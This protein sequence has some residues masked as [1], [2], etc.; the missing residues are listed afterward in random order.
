MIIN[1]SKAIIFLSVILIWSATVAQDESDEPRVYDYAEDN[2]QCLKCHGHKTYHYYNENLEKDHKDRMNPYFI[3]DSVEFYESNHWN[4]SC[5]D[6]HSYDYNDFPH[7]GEL[8]MEEKLNCLDCHEGDDTYADYNFE[9]IDDEFQKSV[10]STL[11]SEEFTCWM[12]HNPHSYKINA[13]TNDQILETIQY[14]NAICLSCHADID[15]YQLMSELANPNLIDKHEWLPNQ[16]LHFLNVRCIECHAEI[17]EDMMIAHNVQPKEKA[18]KLCV[19]CHSSNSLLLASLY[20]FQ[21]IERRNKLGFVNAA[22]LNNSYIIGANRN[23]YLNVISLVMF[24]MVILG[25][26]IHA[27]LRIIKK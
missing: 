19:E 24:G 21:A 27:T 10:H 4:F 7:S 11:H 17:K 23:Y 9:G 15:K 6:C 1:K 8:R 16:A 14:D 22:I 26:G 13:R 12:C 2:H 3:V 25:I 20:K 5:T 18:V